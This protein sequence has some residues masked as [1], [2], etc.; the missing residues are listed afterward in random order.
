[1][2][3]PLDPVV[4]LLNQALVELRVCHDDNKALKEQLTQLQSQ[5]SALQAVA[6]APKATRGKPASSPV[7]VAANNKNEVK[8]APNTVVWLRNKATTDPN[9]MV[10]LVSQNNYDTFVK[11]YED[12]GELKDVAPADRP[13]KIAEKI[14]KSLG[15]LS[16]N[17]NHPKSKEFAVNTIEF[18]RKTWKAEK[19]AF[20]AQHSTSPAATS[21]PVVPDTP[22]LTTPVTSA[23]PD[24]TFA[25]GLT[26]PL[27]QP[28]S[29]NLPLSVGVSR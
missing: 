26:Q 29:L 12:A 3:S 10:Q 14:W 9:F 8:F 28:V 17:S 24:L 7:G 11:K 4:Q 18:L 23:L 21:G 16:E 13:G 20:N 27:V 2:S 15:E 22:V 25:S 1:M 5:V 19:D 6:S